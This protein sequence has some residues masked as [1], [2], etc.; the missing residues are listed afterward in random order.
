MALKTFSSQT[1]TQRFIIASMQSILLALLFGIILCV[2]ADKTD[3][4]EGWILI[5][6]YGV[7][8]WIS[9]VLLFIGVP[10][11]M[12]ER[13]K[14]HG[15]VKKRD[16]TI[17]LAYQSMFFPIFILSGLEERLH[18][19]NS[20][21]Y[22]ILAGIFLIVA[23]FVLLTWSP[24]VNKHLETYI[25]IQTERNH[26]V[27]RR[28]PY[29]F[30]RHPAYLGLLCYFLGIPVTLSSVWGLIP[31]IMASLLVVIRTIVEDRFLKSNL[32]GYT[33]YAEQ[34]RFK[35]VPFIF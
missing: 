25:R 5:V 1:K 30:I 16:R 35:L 4:K 9:S 23:G 32:S 7:C 3:W 12:D 22:L 17:V 34:V 24:L 29:R 8:S 15:G 18:P 26:T 13:K 11:L 28:G 33:D 19:D 27:C 31:A 14:K 10:E 6:T 2:S 21:G 20:P